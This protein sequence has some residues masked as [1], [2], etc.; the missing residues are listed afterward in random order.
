MC[1]LLRMSA[2]LA[3]AAGQERM[4]SVAQ[5]YLAKDIQ[6]ALVL[7]LHRHL[8]EAVAVAAPAALEQLVVI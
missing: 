3:V 1:L 6:E 2:V 8:L 7:S 5:V 4:Q